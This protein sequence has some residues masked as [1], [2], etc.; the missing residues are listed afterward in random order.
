MSREAGGPSGSTSMAPVWEHQ[1]SHVVAGDPV[2]LGSRASDQPVQRRAAA[3]QRSPPALARRG[4]ADDPAAAPARSRL[5]TAVPAICG[6]RQGHRAPLMRFGFPSAIAGH[7]ALPGAASFRAIPLRCSDRIARLEETSLPSRPNR[8]SSLRS[9]AAHPPGATSHRTARAERRTPKASRP[10]SGSCMAVRSGGHVPLSTC[11]TFMA[12]PDARLLLAPAS[13]MGLTALRSFAPT[14]PATGVSARHVPPVVTRGITPGQFRRV[15][16]RSEKIPSPT[17]KRRS[18]SD[19]SGS[20]S[21]TWLGPPA[22]PCG[23]LS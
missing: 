18:V 11:Q 9:F 14:G 16:S 10:G 6:P 2:S 15:T 4:T 1:P 8:T 23:R 3:F 5:V 22:V 19:A 12:W 17:H 13:P 20:A 21:G 7:D